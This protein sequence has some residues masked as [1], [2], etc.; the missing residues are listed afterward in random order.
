MPRLPFDA[1]S[2]QIKAGE[3]PPAIYLWGEEDVLKDEAVRAVL[4]RVVDPGL[5]DFNY[6]VRSAAQLDPDAVEALCT[7]LPMMAD[8][9]LV[10]IRDIEAWS[11]KA[12]AKSAV[13][14]YLEHP[15]AETVLILV[16]G[17]PRRE[18]DRNEADTDLARL[19]AAVEVARCSAK[20]AEKWVLKRAQERGITFDPEA[21]QHLVSAVDGDLGY[22]RS[23]LDKLAGL[24]GDTPVTLAQ[25]TAL[26]GIRHGETPAD[27]CLAVLEDRPGPAAA[28]LTHL[29]D[30]TGVSGVGL[31]I[32]LGSHLVG[33]G[34]ARAQYDTGLRGRALESAVFG[35]IMRARPARLD[36]RGASERWS[37]VVDGWSMPRIDAAIAAARRADRRLKDTTLA[38]ER[39]VL[40]DLI[41]QLAH[42][43]R[44]AA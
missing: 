16:Q 13:L 35:A 36:Y 42:R 14:R 19:A 2:R 20:V 23:E 24:G 28:M 10:V 34:V 31:L 1:F 37:R 12:R 15:A 8:R 29:L 7:T 30:Q 22:A 39:A 44:N 11:K 6:D 5:R 27:W 21:A 32:Q 4:D 9:R 40:I 26:L 25:V 41:M 43:A 17:A 33:L 3:I 18:E 38:D